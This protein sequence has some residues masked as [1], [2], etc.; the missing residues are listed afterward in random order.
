VGCSFPS[1]L[2]GDV[3][4]SEDF[5]ELARVGVC[6]FVAFGFQERAKAS[7]AASG[8]DVPVVFGCC[9]EAFEGVVGFAFFSGL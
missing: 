8:E 3:V 4:F 1:D 6:S 9:C 5:F 2:Y 7:L